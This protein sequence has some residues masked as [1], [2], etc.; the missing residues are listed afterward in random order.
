MKKL[1]LATLFAATS[2]TANAGTIVMADGV[3]LI[4]DSS[5]NLDQGN[6][7]F[8]STFEFIQW[9]NNTENTGTDVDSLSTITFANSQSFVLQGIGEVFMADPSVG[10]IGKLACSGCELTFEFGGLRV[11]LEQT[12]NPVL[13]NALVADGIPVTLANLEAR[14][15]L[16]AGFQVFIPAQIIVPGFDLSQ[17]FLN[18]YIDYTPDLNF[19]GVLDDSIVD[20]TE[21]ANAKNDS[22]WLALE[23]K[24]GTFNA[25]T[26]FADASVFGLNSG[27]S[28]F[29]FDAVGGSALENIDTTAIRDLSQGF[30][31]F[32]DVI[33]LGL[34]ARFTKTGND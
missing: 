18:A 15:T 19:G 6:G 8:N 2:L 16:L 20:A 13:V 26:T 14:S 11:Q 21:M 22:L 5:I 32:R 12:F 17:G 29:T 27:D 1:L 10:A 25:D 34:S 3:T 30:A 28:Y 4:A 24:E 31:I 33:G 7:N 23:F 9:W